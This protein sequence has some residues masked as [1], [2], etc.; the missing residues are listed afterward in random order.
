VSDFIKPPPRAETGPM[1]FGDDWTGVFIR[2]DN[3]FF[4]AMAL[5]E[6]LSRP[7]DVMARNAVQDLIDL[8]R[9]SR[10]VVG[11][12][13]DAQAMKPFSEALK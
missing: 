12:P 11:V 7:D 4:Y 10:H 2:G 5:Q 9:N 6:I 13:K 3:A 1:V 8:L